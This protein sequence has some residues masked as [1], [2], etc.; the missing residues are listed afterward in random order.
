MAMKMEAMS[1][2]GG[3]DS[4]APYSRQI[5]GDGRFA[6]LADAAA[7]EAGMEDDRNNNHPFSFAHN[8]CL[9]H[10]GKASWPW[11]NG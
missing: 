11:H 1:A 4:F 3:G 9:I 10:I 6:I 8:N 2:R 5:H 7:K